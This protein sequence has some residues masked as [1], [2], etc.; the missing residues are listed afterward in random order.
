PPGPAPERAHAARPPGPDERPRPSG[1]QRPAVAD[2][3]EASRPVQGRDTLYPFPQHRDFDVPSAPSA[4]P[5]GVQ[6]GPVGHRPAYPSADSVFGYHGRTAEPPAP[7]SGPRERDRGPFRAPAEA[8]QPGAGPAGGWEPAA[9]APDMSLDGRAGELPQARLRAPAGR[10]GQLL[11]AEPAVA[12]QRAG[13]DADARESAAEDAPASGVAAEPPLGIERGIVDPDWAVPPPRPARAGRL[14]GLVVGTAGAVTGAGAVLPWSTLSSGAETRTFSGLTVG[15]GRVT[16]VVGVVLLMIG[17]ARLFGRPAGA[18]DGVVA[19]VLAAGVTVLSTMD[20]IAGPP[21]LASFRGISADQ[22]SVVPG[23][24]VVLTLV[25]GL[26]ALVGSWLLRPA[27][28][29]R[30]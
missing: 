14:A 29:I 11:S 16:L 17:F 26:V 9:A 24:G 28:V 12:R 5:G 18:A 6:R 23:P 30:R 25:A 4:E 27:R 21:P 22:M 2:R 19:R 7:T 10:S 15:D 1:G 8:G 13:W 3:P 20:I